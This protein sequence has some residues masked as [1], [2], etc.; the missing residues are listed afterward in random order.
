[1]VE[2]W[3]AH[4]TASQASSAAG[5]QSELEADSSFTDNQIA[6]VTG[7]VGQ[8]LLGAGSGRNHIGHLPTG[9]ALWIGR[10]VG[11]TTS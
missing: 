10:H 7:R 9:L 8:G 5:H 11:S 2:A 4:P 3:R 1:V 6:L